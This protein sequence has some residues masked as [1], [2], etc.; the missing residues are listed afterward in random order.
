MPRPRIT[1]QREDL[2]PYAKNI[3]RLR[4]A[5]GLTQ[6]ELA[7]RAGTTS[8]NIARIEAG[9]YPPDMSLLLRLCSTF[10]VNSTDIIEGQAPLSARDKAIQGLV[11][12]LTQLNDRDFGIFIKGCQSL[13]QTINAVKDVYGEP[14][15]AT[16]KWLGKNK[17]TEDNSTDQAKGS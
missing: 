7:E 17:K 1:A 15:E 14:S 6:A 5:S 4:L 2:E 9:R 8:S 16:L 11:L 10:R 13:F 12:G 3:R